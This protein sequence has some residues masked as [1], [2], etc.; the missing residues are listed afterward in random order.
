MLTVE[1][2]CAP[3]GPEHM[4]S[5]RLI[6]SMFLRRLWTLL[7]VMGVVSAGLAAQAWRLTMVEGEKYRRV[8]EAR[9]IADEWTATVRG[10][11]LDR[12]GRVLAQDEASFDILVDY[13]VITG[14]WA[15]SAA[16]REARRAHDD[17]WSKVGRAERERF[18]RERLYDQEVRLRSMWSDL[19]DALGIDL[20]EMER[21]K[22]EIRRRVQQTCMSVW[23]RWLDERREALN[24]E[25]EIIADVTLSDVMRPLSVQREPHAVAVGVSEEVGYAVRRLADHYPGIRVEPSG[26]RSYPHESA[27]IAL[28][29]ATLPGPLREADAPPAL[30]HVEGVATHIVGWMRRLQNEDIAARP[31]VDP[32]TGETD[33]GFYDEGDQ[34]GAAGI[35]GSQERLLRGLRGRRV[36]RRD[37]DEP[38]RVI[39]PRP[40]ADVPLTI[41]VQLQARVQAIMDPSFGLARVQPWH[42]SNAA[43]QPRLEVGTPLFGAAAVLEIDTGEALA[44]VTT[45]SFSR[46][47]LASDNQR[48]FGNPIE[49]AWV[50][51]AVAKPYP[52][53][54]IVKPLIL[55]AA[56]TERVY[57]LDEP[58]LC[59]GH[60]Y[61]NRP[62]ILR[63]W[64]YKQFGTTHSAQ[65]GRGLLGDEGLAVSCNIFFFTLAQ[66]LGAE[67]LIRW[68][69]D[70]GVGERF[71]LGIGDEY[72]GV[73]G[74]PDEA[75]KISP[76]ETAMLGIGQ[77]PLAW[78]PLRA[79][80]AYATI[81]RGGLRLFPRIIRNQTPHAVD[82]RID[83][84]AIDLAL[85]GLRESTQADFGGGQHL[86]Y[87]DGSREP[88]FSSLDRF[89]IIGKTGTAEAPD[90]VDPAAEG[91]PV[92][93]REGDHSWFVVMVG[94]RGGRPRFVIAVIMEYAGSGG[95]VSGPIANQIIQAL[96]DE[97]YL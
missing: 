29:K 35:E 16:A 69:H 60:L 86:T 77:G 24:R 76:S 68:Y 80:D 19:S 41:D 73:V 33:P 39:D 83:P 96:D 56:A 74:G 72:A 65:L 38:T 66:R 26:R 21:R 71:D 51:K 55:S 63:C 93:L 89:D 12:K 84:A 87:P 32:R 30:V 44:L 37:A 64:I 15:Y 52:P 34:V 4:A 17:R 91:G 8:A 53:G 59:T 13:R 92:T 23:E 94:E 75:S 40:G 22:S 7:G 42:H 5:T 18:I 70:F 54:S 95:R 47:E 46:E 61:E 14:E 27:V 25:R 2:L 36:V 81:A 82:L 6:R 9:M 85:K 88:I 11:V 78:T 58:I 28:D 48:L 50:N 20:E 57:R 49:A 43:D 90:L 1:A 3:P 31:R 97:G 10:R 62:D 45:P 67:R 79:A